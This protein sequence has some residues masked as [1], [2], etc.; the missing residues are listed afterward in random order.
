M[1]GRDALKT[2]RKSLSQLSQQRSTATGQVKEVDVDV[3]ARRLTRKEGVDS[4]QR[5]CDMVIK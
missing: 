5:K 4:L 3:C 1:D 2:E